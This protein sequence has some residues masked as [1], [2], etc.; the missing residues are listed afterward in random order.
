[1]EE[2]NIKVVMWFHILSWYSSYQ[3]LNLFNITTKQVTQK[4]FFHPELMVIFSAE[5]EFTAS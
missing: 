5:N 2:T 3:M 4:V 1:M